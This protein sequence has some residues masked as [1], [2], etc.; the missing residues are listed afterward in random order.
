[1]R[2]LMAAATLLGAA[3][4]ALACSTKAN[5]ARDGGDGGGG[6]APKDATTGAELDAATAEVASDAA[7]DAMR[8][9]ESTP[10]ATTFA[11]PD[12]ARKRAEAGAPKDPGRGYR[13]VD[14]LPRPTRCNPPYTTDP[15][16]GHRK[17]KPE[18]IE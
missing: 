9:A 16:T 8:V 15:Q 17:Y 11:G 18:C 6:D 5:D 10:D 4:A 3:N 7:V 13:V 14:P 12:A 2:E 1:M